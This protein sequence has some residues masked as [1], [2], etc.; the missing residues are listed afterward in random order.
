MLQGSV[1]KPP[2]W[3]RAGPW[4]AA[5][6]Q[7]AAAVT[8]VAAAAALPPHTTVAPARCLVALKCREP[9]GFS[10]ENSEGIKHEQVSSCIASRGKEAVIHHSAGPAAGEHSQLSAV[11]AGYLLPAQSHWELEECHPRKAL[12]T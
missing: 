7:V 5:V 10:S 2:H 8:Q 4:L 12:R 9:R 1:L 3:S 11:T 6:T